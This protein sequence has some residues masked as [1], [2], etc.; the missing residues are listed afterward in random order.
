MDKTLSPQQQYAGFIARAQPWHQ[1]HQNVLAEMVAENF[2]PVIFLGSCNADRNSEKNPFTFAERVQIIEK[3]CEQL[4]YADGR[5]VKPIFVPVYD[6]ERTA[7]EKPFFEGGEKRVPL[8]S[9]WFAE[10]V[11]FFK[12][13][14]IRP[15]QFTLF[16][17]A[18]DQDTKN[19]VF[20][21]FYDVGGTKFSFPGLTG[22][23]V[24][25]DEDLS[26]AFKLYGAKRREMPVTAENATDIRVDFS[27]NKALLVPGTAEV[28]DGILKTERAKNAAYDGQDI[29]DEAFAAEPLQVLRHER[30]TRDIHLQKQP[31]D[32]GFHKNVLLVGGAGSLGLAVIESMLQNVHN[33]VLNHHAANVEKFK[34]DVEQIAARYPGR[35]VSFEECD[36]REPK[37][38]TPEF[39]R[40]TY[41][42]HGIDG[43]FN[44]AGIIEEKPSIGLTFENVNYRPVKAMAQAAVDSGIDRMVYVS[45][46][47]AGNP[48][49]Q[50]NALSQDEPLTYAGSKRKAEM[51]LEEFSGK[52]N[53]ISVRPITVFNPETPDW[54]RPMTFPHLANLAFMP[55][56]GSGQQKLQPLYIGDLAKAARLIESPLEGGHIFEA[57]GPEQVTLQKAMTLL[58]RPT[59]AFAAVNVPYDVAEFLAQN[60]PFGGI[61]PS[62][63][64]VMKQR[65][66]F[67]AAIPSDDW[68]R[69]IGEEGH[70]T[71]LEDIYAAPERDLQFSEPPIVEYGGIIAKN[72]EPLYQ[73]LARKMGQSPLVERFR[74]AFDA[75]RENVGSREARERVKTTAFEILQAMRDALGN[76][77]DHTPKP[78][79]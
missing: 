61:N 60:Y 35:T 29:T 41:Q 40:E 45:T 77:N 68:A 11:D 20:E 70:L 28:I 73:F 71:S 31:A 47:T 23:T 46:I 19:Y 12:E 78:A 76:D 39:W 65:E 32:P 75:F 37:T 64:K 50:A 6:H 4:R 27:G 63:V 15:D 69:A 72:P 10:F 33:L 49:A 79:T 8:N 30:R 16:Y 57:V 44:M 38:W 43:V 9:A 17:S 53:W 74:D 18:K 59:D 1:G 54:G 14:G 3:A 51:A 48:D 52:L 67:E 7:E 21:P 22:K 26:L 42:R 36:L 66:S 56:L 58:R 5:T 13:S 25:A 34:Q 24:F 2:Q 55:I 62:F